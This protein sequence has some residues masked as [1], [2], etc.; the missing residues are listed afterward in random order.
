MHGGGWTVGKPEDTDL[1]TRKLSLKADCEVISIDYRLAPEFPYPAALNDCLA[2][3][4]AVRKKSKQK[5]AV[6]GDSCGGGLAYSMALVLRDKKEIQPNGIV[7]ICPVTDFVIEKYPSFLKMG[8]KSLCYDYGFLNFIRSIYLRNEQWQDPY[9]SPMYANLS[10]L[11]PSFILSAGKDPL[12]DENIAFVKKM[13]QVRCK[14]EHLIHDEMPHA[15]YYFL[16]LSKEE[17][18]AYDAMANFLKEVYER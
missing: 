8:P 9:V 15:Y 16:G 3:Y 14:I 5:I 6:A 12:I 18:I 10:N 2:V 4:R 7:S 11:C 17:A 1:V 13:K